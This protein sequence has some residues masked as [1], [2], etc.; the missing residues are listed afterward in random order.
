MS[1]LHKALLLTAALSLSTTGVLAQTYTVG[2]IKIAQPWARA[3]P[4]GAK[5][6]A[7]YMTITNSGTQPDRLIGGTL[8]Q[9]GEVQVHE[10][11]MANGTMEMRDVAG[12]LEIGAGQ[13]VELKPGG[14]HMMFMNLH[15]P[16]KQGETIKGQLR[17]EKAGTVDVEYHVEAVGAQSAPHH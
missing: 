5:V 2:A 11:K 10:M 16:L 6:G 4:G 8:P 1:R 17:F 15:D 3:T 12:G 7:G 13:T 14:Y 9:A